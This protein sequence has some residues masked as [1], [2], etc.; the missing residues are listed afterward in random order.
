MTIKY[1]NTKIIGLAMCDS[2]QVLAS[3]DLV[4]KLIN[5]RKTLTKYF[6]V[7]EGVS[8]NLIVVTNSDKGAERLNELLVSNCFV[9]GIERE[10][11]VKV[12]SFCNGKELQVEFNPLECIF[13]SDS[14]RLT[15]NEF[16]YVT[17][18]VKTLEEYLTENNLNEESDIKLGSNS[19]Q[20]LIKFCMVLSK[21]KDRFFV[22][23]CK[24]S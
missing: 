14:T 21:Y 3:S 2:I 17:K 15:L 8:S 18:D 12:E 24:P 19:V 5:F 10:F 16:L 11:K 6:N 4:T 22:E 23:M 9:K 1:K 7:R 20:A 13:E